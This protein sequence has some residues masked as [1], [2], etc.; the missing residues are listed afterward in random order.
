MDDETLDA[1]ATRFLER[2]QNQ[3]GARANMAR[4]TVMANYLK[5]LE[6]LEAQLKI[7]FFLF[8]TRP[9]LRHRKDRRSCSSETILLLASGIQSDAIH[10]QADRLCE[11]QMDKLDQTYLDRSAGL[12]RQA[13][14]DAGL[15]LR[16]VAR[17]A[18]TS[19]ATVL[20][21]ECAR[22]PRRSLPSCEFSNAAGTASTSSFRR[23]SNIAT[24]S[25]AA[26]S[27]NACWNWR[28]NFPPGCRG[29]CTIRDSR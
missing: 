18:G 3:L 11:V 22:K 9:S 13:R 1:M 21:Y 14:L 15:S 7:S 6:G 26:T 2:Q 25:N 8:G 4:E 16:E 17:R 19:H 24:E 20:A 12:L 27:W 5:I 23:A 28:P 29:E 10:R